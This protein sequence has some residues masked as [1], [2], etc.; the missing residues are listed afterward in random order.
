MSQTSDLDPAVLAQLREKAR[1]FGKDAGCDPSRLM[2]MTLTDLTR[3][4][5][6][7]YRLGLAHGRAEQLK[8]VELAMNALESDATVSQRR[9]AWNMLR[10]AFF[11]LRAGRDDA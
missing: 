7:A 6:D 9:E 1:A 5:A 8:V 10:D 3:L 11:P 2:R 4:A